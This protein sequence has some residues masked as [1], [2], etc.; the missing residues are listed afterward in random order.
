M[1]GSVR[2]NAVL[3]L[4][5]LP[6]YFDPF[7]YLAGFAVCASV[8][9]IFGDY[10]GSVLDSFTLIA[11]TADLAFAL[12]FQIAFFG[13]AP[14][15]I[16]RVVR[17]RLG[18]APTYVG[19]CGACG[20]ALVE[21]AGFCSVCGAQVPPLAHASRQSFCPTCGAEQVERVVPQS[22][23]W[24]APSPPPTWVAAPP[25]PAPAP[26]VQQRSTFSGALLDGPPPPDTA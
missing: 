26:V 10:S 9:N 15:A 7:V 11:I 4:F 24:A 8:W 19:S 21:G 20:A 25:Q 13:V 6:L 3:G 16:R 18:A 23:R 12:F 14:A 17:R 5:D 1:A 22:Q 2:R